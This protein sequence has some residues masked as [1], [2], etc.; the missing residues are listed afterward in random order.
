MKE[1]AARARAVSILKHRLNHRFAVSTPAIIGVGSKSP[2]TNRST[3][4][5]TE[6]CAPVLVKGRLELTTSN[7]RQFKLV[8]IVDRN[9]RKSRRK[10]EPKPALL[11][12]LYQKKTMNTKGSRDAQ[13][14]W[15]VND[16]G[17]RHVA[18]GHRRQLR[19]Y[20]RKHKLRHVT[21]YPA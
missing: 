13:H 15:W 5:E 4:Y 11:A 21:S 10:S 17:D 16:D 12:S 1:S 19:H 2:T 18:L 8:R 20:L 6:E 9:I 14:S 7:L 3:R